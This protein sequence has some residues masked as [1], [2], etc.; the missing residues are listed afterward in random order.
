MIYKN[1]LLVDWEKQSTP[2]EKT[3]YNEI[4]EIKNT[5]FSDNK[6]GRLVLRYPNG[7]IKEVDK[8]WTQRKRFAIPLKSSDGRWRYSN[9]IRTDKKANNGYSDHHKYIFD[10]TV[11]TIKDVEFVWFLKNKSSVVGKYIFFEDLEADAKAEVDELASDA[12][13]RFMI[14]SQ[15]SPIAKN[16]KLIKQMASVFGVS[17]VE[18]IGIYQV[19]KELYDK[20]LD[21]ESHGDR[22]CNYATFDKLVNGEKARK[23]AYIARRAI[24]DKIVGY[25]DRAWWI[26]D[27]RSYEERLISMSA[28]DTDTRDQVLIEAVVEDANVRSRVFGVMGEEEN[29]TLEDLREMDRPSLQ[30][31][32]RELTGQ[33]VNSKKEE[34]IEALCKEK[35]ITFLPLTAQ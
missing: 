20:L 30:K 31:M 15:K 27:G 32:L 26:M 18:K 17:N 35:G 12:D 6:L 22:F 1:N 29:V 14:M 28:T 4:T 3:V 33:F 8:G 9:S 21:G 19:K 25:K 2:D 10:E 11:F 7:Q 5:Y 16:E 24:E 23:A 34:I 13:I